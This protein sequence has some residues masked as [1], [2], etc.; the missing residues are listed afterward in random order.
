MGIREWL[1]PVVEDVDTPAGR[2]FDLSVG[3]F[4]LATMIALA[5]E[6]LPSLSDTTRGWLHA[7]E[8]LSLALFA[9]EYALRLWVAGRPLRYALSFFG[10]VDLVSILPSLVFV[11]I[12][13]RAVRVL[14]LVRVVRLLK[15]A[16]YNAAVRRLHRALLLAWEELVLFLLASLLL[17]FL[18][19]VGIYQFEHHAQPE[20]FPSIPHSLW[21][22][23]TTL[24]TVGYGDV[25]PITAGGRAFT[26]VVLVI[27]LGVVAMPAGLIASALTKARELETTPPVERQSPPES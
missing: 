21:W 11:T 5:V 14:R 24:T 13:S 6:T 9:A 16:R 15:L 8:R 22:A 25:F 4:I 2:A 26:F 10:L 20:A 23:V 17:L 12:D 27:G 18:A 7:F 19:A 3:A 1:R